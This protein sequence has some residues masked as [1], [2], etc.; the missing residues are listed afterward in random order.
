MQSKERKGS[1]FAIWQPWRG[2]LFFLPATVHLSE[3]QSDSQF[4]AAWGYRISI[5][6]ATATVFLSFLR[7]VFTPWEERQ[8]GQSLCNYMLLMVLALSAAIT[9]LLW[10]AALYPRT[11]TVPVCRMP[12]RK[13]RETKE[14]PSR[15][16]SGHQISCCWNSLHFLA[17]ILP[18]GARLGLLIFGFYFTSKSLLYYQ[19]LLVNME[20]S[21]KK[22]LEWD[23]VQN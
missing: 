1:N 23:Q 16:K 9:P 18:R 10:G 8:H 2:P 22:Y 3:P 17:V 20:Q 7:G 14:Q 4:C 5:S 12:H 13:W 15:S 21:S 11:P 19:H 6:N